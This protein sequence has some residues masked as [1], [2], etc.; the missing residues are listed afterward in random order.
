MLRPKFS[1]VRQDDVLKHQ[2]PVPRPARRVLWTWLLIA[3]CVV[4][5]VAVAYVVWQLL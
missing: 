5:W 1:V 2:M 3:G 4:F